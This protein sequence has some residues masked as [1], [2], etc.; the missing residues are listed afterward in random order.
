MDANV[1]SSARM[2]ARIRGECVTSGKPSV[3]ASLCA[4]R[5]GV[6]CSYMS[7]TLKRSVAGFLRSAQIAPTA[8]SESP[9]SAI[10]KSSS[11]EISPVQLTARANASQIV[12]SFTLRA[13]RIIL[14]CPSAK[15]I[16]GKRALSILPA[17]VRGMPSIAA[18]RAGII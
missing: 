5:S 6:R 18:N 15:R 8:E 14:F 9:P 13:H 4:K 11:I 10:K 12:C 16:S 3:K 17:T 1:G 2:P 7:R